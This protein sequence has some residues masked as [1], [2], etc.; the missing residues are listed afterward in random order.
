MAISEPAITRDSDVPEGDVGAISNESISCTGRDRM[1]Y[2]GRDHKMA[3][4]TGRL[5]M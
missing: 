3:C 2:S 5:S 4:K 1:N